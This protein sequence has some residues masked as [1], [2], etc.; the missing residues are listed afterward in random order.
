[1]TT[2]QHSGPRT[3]TG[4]SGTARTPVGT[5]GTTAWVGIAWFAGAMA[6]ISGLANVIN[7]LIAIFD[8]EYY[9]VTAGGELLVWDFT[10]WGWVHLLLGVALFALGALLVARPT[11]GV[12]VT[13]AS[14]AGLNAVAQLA[15]LGVYPVY[16]IVVLA[17]DVLVIWGLLA[18][19]RDIEESLA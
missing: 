15:Y 3:D 2:S 19:G 17:L 5:R 10:V 11:P 18:H 16:S 7:G 13:A 12:R 1:M 6:M 9:T 8:D 4:T 14:L